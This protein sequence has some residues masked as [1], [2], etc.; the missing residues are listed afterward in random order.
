MGT[1]RSK[2]RRSLLAHDCVFKKGQAAWK[3]KGTVSAGLPEAPGA[4]DSGWPLPSRP[5]L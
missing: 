3:M 1:V 2:A 5:L 4:A